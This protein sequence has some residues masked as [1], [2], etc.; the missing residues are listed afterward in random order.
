[1]L[2]LPSLAIKLKQPGG[3]TVSVAITEFPRFLNA[4]KSVPVRSLE[5]VSKNE[6]R[7]QFLRVSYQTCFDDKQH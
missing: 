3:S 1:M 5:K 2:E 6:L 7:K 4:V